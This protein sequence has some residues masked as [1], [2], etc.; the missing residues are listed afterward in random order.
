MRKCSNCNRDFDDSVDFC[1]PC[2]AKLGDEAQ[3]N[4]A[5]EQPAAAP[6]FEQPQAQAPYRSQFPRRARSIRNRS[7]LE[8]G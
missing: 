6:Q 2:G 1:P 4:T 3:A 8:S 7:L 5:F